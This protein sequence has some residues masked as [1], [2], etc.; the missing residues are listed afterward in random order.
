MSIVNVKTTIH[1]PHKL[2]WDTLS[3]L[4]GIYKWASGITESRIITDNSSKVGTERS[5]EISQIGTIK[6][7]ITEWDEGKGLKYE[8]L[9]IPNTPVR[10]GKSSWT[11]LPEDD[12]FI[13]GLSTEFELGGNET[14]NQEFLKQANMLLSSTLQDLKHYIETILNEH[15][16]ARSS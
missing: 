13:I 6:E 16:R 8:I 3:D 15:H 9:P 7:K 4:G 14:E 2:I 12:H 10:S 11:L 5:C 1:A